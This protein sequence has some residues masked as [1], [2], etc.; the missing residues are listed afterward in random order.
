MASGLSMAAFTGY[1]RIAADKHYLSDVLTGAIVG[2]AVG[3][4]V[5]YFLHPRVDE[6]R[7]IVSM[8]TSPPALSFTWTR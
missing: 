3:F 8:T 6:R 5:P 2:S 1:L 7:P 4:V